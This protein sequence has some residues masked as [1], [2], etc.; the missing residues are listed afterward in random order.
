MLTLL[1][2]SISA[3]WADASDIPALLDKLFTAA[4]SS[5][6]VPGISVAVADNRGIV[7]AQGYGYAD[8][9]N[10]VAMT[11]AHK[12]RIGSVAKVITTAGLMRLYQQ[13]KIDF[14]APVTQYVPSWPQDKPTITLRQLTSHTA[15]IRHYKE[16]A[17]EFLLNTPFA[18]VTASLELFKQ[19]PLLF[20]PGSAFSYS[21]FGWTLVSAAMEGADGKRSFRQIMQQEVFQPLQL[22]DMVF[23]DQYAIISQRARPY[24]VHEGLLQNSPQTDHSYKWAAGGFIAT[25]S[26]VDRFALAQLDNDYLKPAT[27]ALMFSKAHLTDG[28]P[29]NFGIGWMIGFDNYRQRAKYRDDAEALAMMAD[30][31]QAVMHSGGSMGGITMTIMCREHQRAV[32][33]VKNVDGD[34]TA[35]VFKLALTTLDYYHQRQQ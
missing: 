10:H 4:I 19:D 18:S 28:T 27:Q 26:D 35:D 9:E 7:W 15:G 22:T 12:L 29:V 23:D 33:V 8:L 21:T 17:N 6:T 25:P 20:T 24:S 30:M 2:C 3:A 16:G 13:G 14:D 11:P 34:D 5:P 31:P 32:T 1:S